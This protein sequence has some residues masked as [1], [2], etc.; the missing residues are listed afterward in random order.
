MLTFKHT[1]SSSGTFHKNDLT[2]MIRVSSML[3]FILF[4]FFRGQN[5]V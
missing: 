4:L 3:N 1:Y 2:G 5:L